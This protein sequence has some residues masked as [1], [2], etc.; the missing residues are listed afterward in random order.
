M[1]SYIKR[2]I[3]KTLI[4]D[5]N[6]FPVVALL[7][8]R[9]CGKSTLALNLKKKISHFLYLD[10]DSISDLRKLEDPELFFNSNKDKLVCLDEIQNRPDLFP[11]L[12]SILDRNNKNGQVLI[13]GS[14]SRDLIRQSSESLAG[15][16]SYLELTPFL[17]SEISKNKE[18]DIKK[19]WMRG[20]FPD[21][22]L[23]SNE[24]YSIKWR[25]NFIRT[26]LE[27]DIPQLGLNI[28]ANRLRRLWMMCAHGHGQVFNSSRLGESLGITY[29]TVRNYIDLLEQ[30]FIL[31]VLPPLQS[32]LKKRLIKSPKVYIR[33]S[34][35]L[36]SILEIEDF[37][38]LLGHLILG[39]SWEGFI[40]ENILSEFPDWR[41]SYYRTSS[42]TEI[43]LILE[44]GQK[45]IAIE[46]KAS[47]APKPGKGFWNSLKELNIKN[48]WIIAPV[49]DVY[50][51]RKNV[52][53]S[54][55]K[56]FIVGF[57]S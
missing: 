39:A 45:R 9:Q 52:F 35:L 21:S 36:H 57:E 33:D 15:R 1:Q 38:D 26:F 56:N 2:N 27:R 18:I 46:L 8:P 16:I 41:A 50:P 25:K 11:V 3:E 17:H 49:D 34:G 42:G 30:T 37:N 54:S 43:D 44:K 53:V 55:L 47:S 20:G 22:Y 19:I 24:K 7:G 28:P 14:A 32:N 51:I 40:I 5:L 12:R 23:A 31:R 29:H 6:H 13:L 48:A 4:D 10:L